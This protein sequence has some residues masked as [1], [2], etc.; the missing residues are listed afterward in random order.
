MS[1]A[2]VAAAVLQT[3]A[4]LRVLLDCC[5][6]ADP[7][8]AEDDFAERTPVRNSHDDDDLSFFSFF[9]M[10]ERRFCPVHGTF[11]RVGVEII[12]HEGSRVR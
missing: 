1:Y 2:E 4:R 12:S 11:G 7:T 9:R 5:P 6:G 10:R 3:R 8:Q